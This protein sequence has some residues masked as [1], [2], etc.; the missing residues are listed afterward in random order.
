MKVR[1]GF[2]S[3]SSSS[4]FVIYGRTYNEETLNKKF[5]INP[6]EEIEDEDGE[7][8]IDD[9]Q[10]Y[11]IIE[12]SGFD[13]H[14]QDG[15]CYIGRQIVDM[16]ENETLF[17]FKKRIEREVIEKFGDEKDDSSQEEFDII[18]AVIG[19]GGELEW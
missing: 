4:S 12:K 7:S 6:D 3:N 15:E 18:N 1:T 13:Y 10:L 9:E 8:Y 2:V 5:G 17:N 14:F 16:N 19:N 11:D